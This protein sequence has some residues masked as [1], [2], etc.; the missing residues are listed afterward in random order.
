M[1]LFVVTGRLVCVGIGLVIKQAIWLFLLIVY[2]QA[3]LDEVYHLF[4]EALGELGQRIIDNGILGCTQVILER[5][6][7]RWLI[8]FAFGLKDEVALSE[9]RTEFTFQL[10]MAHTG[11]QVGH[12]T[13]QMVEL[14]RSSTKKVFLSLMM[15]SSNCMK[16]LYR[17]SISPNLYFKMA[18]SLA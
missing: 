9:L 6:E 1:S 2:L 17:P 11:A 5:P 8:G 13:E 4:V 18:W 3:L 14:E 12:K 15:M 16:R 10:A 7:R